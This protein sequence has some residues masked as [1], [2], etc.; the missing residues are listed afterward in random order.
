MAPV[1]RVA[2]T[3]TRGRHGPGR[4]TLFVHIGQAKTGSKSIQHVLHG[5]SPMLEQV[6]L[7]VLAAGAYRGNHSA[8][9]RPVATVHWNAVAREAMRCRAGRLV[10][11]GEEFTNPHNQDR[12]IRSLLMLAEEADL[13]VSVIGYVRPQWQWIEAFYPLSVKELGNRQRFQ[14]T[15]PRLLHDA[16]L[17]YASAFEPW[18]KA[19]GRLRVYPLEAARREGLGAHFLGALGVADR[20]LCSAVA[21][22]P[23][24]NQRPG[25]KAIEVYRLVAVGLAE[26]GVAGAAHG[27]LMRHLEG[28]PTLLPDDRAFTGLTHAQLDGLRRRFAPGNARFARDFGFDIDAEAFWNAPDEAAERPTDAGWGDLSAAEQAGVRD[29]VRSRMGIDLPGPSRGLKR[30]VRPADHRKAPS[31]SGAMRASRRA[32]GCCRATVEIAR[33]LVAGISTARSRRSVPSVARWLHWQVL[34]MPSRF[35]VAVRRLTTADVG[36]TV[37]RRETC[38]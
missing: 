10:I 20:D 35:R 22:H 5:W 8:L 29:F 25:A 14:D 11:S 3:A 2:A 19:F 28:L 12:A 27:R 26:L 38:R 34:A 37:G 32:A 6:D 13:D 7:H 15:L 33:D 30:N 24:D 17:D 9:T 18:R 16:R 4:R 23:R 1:Q 31:E 36:R 21:R